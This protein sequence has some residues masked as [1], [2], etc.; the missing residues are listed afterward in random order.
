K[1]SKAKN[2]GK[3]PNKNSD[4]KTD[5]NLVDKEEQVFLD[6]LEWLKRQEQDAND[7]A[8]ALKKE[9]AKDTEDLLLQAG[10]AKASITNTVNTASTPVSTD[11]PEV[12]TQRPDEDIDKQKVSTDKEEVSTDRPDEGT[13]DQN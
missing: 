1:S 4:L 11:K 3:E 5:E 12:S 9:F 2:A 6:E 10:A 7:V 13:V 8:E